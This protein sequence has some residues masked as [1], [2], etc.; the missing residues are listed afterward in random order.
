MKRLT[1]TLFLA[2]AGL[3]LHAQENTQNYIQTR[4]QLNAS[5]SSYVENISYHDGLGRQY[6]VV[7]RAVK[8][9]T[10]TGNVLASLQEYDSAGR[11]SSAWLPAV[12]SGTYLEASAFKSQAVS[13]YG[14]DYPY[15]QPVYE[16]SPLNRPV[17]QYGAGAAWRTGNHSVKTEYLLNTASDNAKHYSIGS[18]GNPVDNGDYAVHTLQVVKTTDEDGKVGYTF[19]DKLGNVVLERRMNGTESLDTYNVYDDKGNLC[20]VLQPG[21]QDSTAADRLELYAFR[22]SYNDW[23]LCEKKELPG[24]DSILYRYNDRQLLSFSQDGNQRASGKWSYYLYD[25]LCRLIEQG[26]CSDTLTL[27]DKMVYIRNHYDDYSFVGSGN[28]ASGYT[29]GNATY[30]KGFLTGKEVTVLGS[31][32]KLCTVYHYDEKGRVIKSMS[33]NLLGGMEIV[34]NTY[35]FTG[36]PLTVTHAHTATGKTSRTE[37]YTYSY[38]ERD[39]LNKIMHK[40]G[41]TTV[42]LAEYTYDDLDRLATKKLHGNNTNT[43][44]YSYNIR[45]WLTGISS[46]KF[47]QTL[48]YGSNYNGNISSMN[49]NANGASHSYTFTYDGV[50]RMLNAT[51]GTGAYTEKVTLYDKNGNI[52]ALQRYG[53]GLIDNL[54][55]TYSGNQ[56]TKVEDATGNAAGFSNG[57]STTNEYV[58]DNNGN[59]TKDSNKGITNIAYNSLSLPSTVTFSD[60]STIT[61]SYAANGMKLRTVHTIS[62]TTTTKDYCANVVYENGV[63]KLLLTEEGYVDLSASTLTYYYYLKDHQGNNRVVINSSGTVQE[64]NHY[65]PFGSLFVNTS[66]QPYKYNGKELDTKKGLNWYDYGAR[67]YDATLG[68]W[69]VVDPLAEK[70]SAWSPYAYCFNNPIKYVDEE[71]EFPWAALIGPAIDY[72]LQVYDN[73]QKG[74]DGYNAWVGNVDFASVALSAINPTGKFKIVGTLLAEGTKATVKLKPNSGFE[75]S[76][77]GGEIIT[78]TI[79]NTLV[80]LGAGK[81]TES[82]TDDFMN[83]VNKEMNEANINVRKAKNRTGRQPNSEKHKVQLEKAQIEAEQVRKKQVVTYIMNSTVGVMNPNVVEQTVTN[84]FSIIKKEWDEKEKR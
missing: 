6:Q 51:H 42:T 36:Q 22:Y 60:G 14:D 13:Q 61:Y 62:G 10:Q 2:F 50:N 77:D 56:L 59:L 78:N 25:G 38:D 68:R 28:F 83:K 65:Y 45:N 3:F 52:K 64:T 58:Y 80:S 35:S 1:T 44:T 69:L 24:A 29:S 47:T 41:S 15:M 82:S 32:D 9:G 43:A 16:A 67:H 19:T 8:S 76:S 49:W 18:N 21:Y 84:G 66:V 26:E 72:G 48:G 17:S 73:Y 53:N 7:E 46:T 75:M 39:R 37:V 74:K 34:T 57:A 11:E 20:I 63:Q 4:T 81:L 71:G 23:N 40:L 5:G 27:S 33:G 54:T 79:E 70:M 12:I 55:Y 30:G 31:S